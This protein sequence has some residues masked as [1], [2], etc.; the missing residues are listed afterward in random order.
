M[1]SISRSSKHPAAPGTFEHQTRATP[2]ALRGID[3]NVPWLVGADGPSNVVARR[4]QRGVLFFGVFVVGLSCCILEIVWLNV[5][6][7]G[8]ACV[9]V[10]VF[11]V[12]VGRFAIWVPQCS[13]HVGGQGFRNQLLL[14]RPPNKPC[15]SAFHHSSDGSMRLDGVGQEPNGIQQSV[16]DQLRLLQEQQ[17]RQ[18]EALQRLQLVSP[19][20]HKRSSSSP[21]SHAHPP[22][23][24]RLSKSTAA[25]S[26]CSGEGGRCTGRTT[27]SIWHPGLLGLCLFLSTYSCC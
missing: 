26:H 21:S 16:T 8:R 1:V 14:A 7:A 4:Y 24:R 5:C 22:S 17:K 10:L 19:N 9:W 12:V 3:K 2:R 25:S 13:G 11:I 15:S 6:D 18:R 23:C 27:P 20:S